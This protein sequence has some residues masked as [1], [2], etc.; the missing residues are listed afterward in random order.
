MATG[1]VPTTANSP[2]TVKGDLFGYSTTQARVPVGNDGETLVADSSTSTGLRYQ[3][4]YNGN[5]CINGGMDFWQRGTSSTTLGYATADRWWTN[6]SAGTTTISQETTIVPTGF[7]YSQKLTQ[8][9]SAAA[10][11]TY[12]AMETSTALM[13]AGQTI[14][15]SALV[16]A[17]AST[18]VGLEMSF[19]TSVDNGI[20]GTWTAITAISGGSTT[21]TSTTFVKLSG[22]YAIPSTAKSLRIG[23]SI[24]SITSG[25]SFYWTGMQFE[26]G[27]VPTTFKRSGGTIQGELAACQRYFYQ[28]VNSASLP[29]GAGMNYT[30]SDA[31]GT[32]SLPVAMRIAP[33]ISVVTGTNYYAF[34]RNGADDQVNSVT[35]LEASP[36]NISYRNNTEISGTAGNGG[37]WLSY[38]N[39]AS[40]GVSAEL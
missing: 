35:L 19:S 4:G 29:F 17:S 36:T 37:Y 40:I 24:P 3:S 25:T 28:L 13:F 39:S 6:N 31:H 18:A 22:V 38:N 21:P 8:S 5:A 12:Q 10:L 27:S 20:N 34:R 16:A 26:F 33:T 14:S 7:R 2:L 9:V 32:V 1:R 11:V 30:A 23:I 15:L